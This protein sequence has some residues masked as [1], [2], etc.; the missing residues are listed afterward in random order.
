MYFDH[1]LKQ[2]Q[3]GKQTIDNKD[4]SPFIMGESAHKDYAGINKH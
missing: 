1:C 3:Q 4:T 2:K